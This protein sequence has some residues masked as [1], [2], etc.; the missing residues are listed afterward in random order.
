[1]HASRSFIETDNN[2]SKP[3]TPYDS[4]KYDQ[5]ANEH[6]KVNDL[7]K[8][9]EQVPKLSRYGGAKSLKRF[10]TAASKSLYMSNQVSEAPSN[11]NI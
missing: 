9:N 7:Q 6:T 4:T 8:Y 1:M 5:V 10:S 11:A 2:K 3:S